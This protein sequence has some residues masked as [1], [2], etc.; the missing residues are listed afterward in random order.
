MTRN[1]IPASKR[2]NG[3]LMVSVIFQSSWSIRQIKKQLYVGRLTLNS[4]AYFVEGRSLIDFAPRL[5]I[6][7][8][9]D[10]KWRLS[11]KLAIF[12]GVVDTN[13][14]FLSWIEL[15][16]SVPALVSFD[17]VYFGFENYSYLW[18]FQVFFMK[19]VQLKFNINK[20][21]I[22]CEDKIS[23]TR[24]I[25]IYRSHHTVCTEIFLSHYIK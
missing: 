5:V 3:R 25:Y 12:C 13:S 6:V 17:E 9:Q 4:L 24:Q 21:Q 18:P 2:A 19:E 11:W 14:G 20:F 8:I 22:I 16:W 15:N 23:C 7:A 1:G 10:D